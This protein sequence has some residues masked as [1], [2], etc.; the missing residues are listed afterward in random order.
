[1]ELVVEKIS[2]VAAEL[3]TLEEVVEELTLVG[4]L[5]IMTVSSVGNPSVPV[6]VD[7]SVDVVVKVPVHGSVVVVIK[8]DEA[9]ELVTSEDVAEE[10]ALVGVLT[11][12]TVSSVGNPSV[13]VIVDASV[14]VVVKGPVHGS[15]VVVMI[16]AAEDEL[17][18]AGV[19]T[20][21]TVSSVGNPSVPVIVDASVDVVVKV[22]VLS[23]IHI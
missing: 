23:L 9:E 19:L 4:V 13:P 8:P 5:T 7:A 1:M 10:L 3:V 15:V 22:P 16:P 20:M 14:D 12:M 21:M 11:I 6:I 18:L 17:T 2:D